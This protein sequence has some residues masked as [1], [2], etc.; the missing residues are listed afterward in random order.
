[1]R[2]VTFWKTVS[3]SNMAEG[4]R[5]INL[6]E[7]KSHNVAGSSWLVIHNKVFD[8]TKFLDEVSKVLLREQQVKIAVLVK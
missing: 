8:V 1:M 5:K 6:E 4:L 3:L 7:V 2:N